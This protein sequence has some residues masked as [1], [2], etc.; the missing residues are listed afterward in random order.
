M[1]TTNV[2]QG[3]IKSLDQKEYKTYLIAK[4]HLG[5]SF[6]ISK[7]IGFLEWKRIQNNMSSKQD[8][9]SSS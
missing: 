5:N 8:D 4:K 9:E 6:D 1:D 7:S 3:Y 2:E